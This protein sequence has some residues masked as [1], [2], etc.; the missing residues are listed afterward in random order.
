MKESTNSDQTLAMSST[1]VCELDHNAD[2]HVEKDL[3]G[4]RNFETK[5]NFTFWA[6]ATAYDIFS[7]SPCH[8]A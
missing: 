2:V 8:R 5:S 4:V 3:S 6:A 1:P 7:N